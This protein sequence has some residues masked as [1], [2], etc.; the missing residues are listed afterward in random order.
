MRRKTG[1]KLQTKRLLEIDP[2]KLQYAHPPPLF[3]KSQDMTSQFNH[4]AAG[5]HANDPIP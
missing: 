3:A 4:Q 1:D 5:K 2:A